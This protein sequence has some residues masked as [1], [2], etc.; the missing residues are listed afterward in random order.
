MVTVTFKRLGFRTFTLNPSTFLKYVFCKVKS[1]KIFHVR[2]KGSHKYRQVLLKQR[3]K[4]CLVPI[5]SLVSQ[6]FESAQNGKNMTRKSYCLFL[7]SSFSNHVCYSVYTLNSKLRNLVCASMMGF[8]CLPTKF[9]LYQSALGVTSFVCI[10]FAS[11][12][13]YM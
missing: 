13:I 10:N 12:P 5:S 3:Y 9:H 11:F 1:K 8:I 4:C 2:A 6:P 7:F